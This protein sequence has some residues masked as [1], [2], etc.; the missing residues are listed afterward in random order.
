MDT[1]LRKIGKIPGALMVVPLLAGALTNTFAG[2]ALEIGSFTT[3]LFRDGTTVLIALF[4]VAVGS[5]INIKSAVPSLEKGAVLLVAKLAVAVAVGLGIAFLTPDGTLWG[6]LPLAVVAAMSNS[7]GSLY[8]A[9]TSQFGSKTDKGAISVLSINDGPF[10][11][12]IALGAAG[13]ADFPVQSLVAAIL[14]LVIGFVLGN[15]STLAREFLKPG[16]QLIIP[17]AGFAIGAGI[18]FG[19]LIRSGLAGVFLGFVVLLFSGSATIGAI[20]LWHRVKR[21]PKETRNLVG[22]AAES[23]VA[24][25]AIA[26]PA[27]IAQIDPAYQS[28]VGEATAQVATAVVVTTFLTPFLVAFI[29]KWQQRRG[30][31]PV[32]EDELFGAAENEG[33]QSDERKA[34]H[35]SFVESGS[36]LPGAAYLHE[37]E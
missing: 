19:E 11:T 14:P 9:L 12:M 6:L 35:L 1:L 22:G 26:T 21:H 10:L 17:F 25:N 20:Y 23:A 27:A 33:N 3:A 8:V 37:K 5:Q 34:T 32:K 36:R 31:D 29:A 18:D 24:G 15:T 2:E 7:S 16:E 13:L 4:F 30:V 28:I